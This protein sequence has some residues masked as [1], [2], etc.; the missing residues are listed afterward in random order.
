MYFTRKQD[1]L[2]R[3]VMP[4]DPE[5]LQR[6]VRLVLAHIMVMSSFNFDT[7]SLAL[8]VTV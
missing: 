2:Q 7:C 5:V 8:M 3:S 4:S 1:T 6:I